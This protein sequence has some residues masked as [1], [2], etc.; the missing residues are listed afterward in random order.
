MLIM[1]HESV[2]QP[3]AGEGRPLRILVAEDNPLNQMVIAAVLEQMGHTSDI[4]ADGEAALRKAQDNV[5]DLILMDMMMPRMDGLSAIRA[6]RALSEPTAHIPIIMMTANAMPQD[7]AKSS[8]AGC[9]GFVPKPID[10]D[11]LSAEVDR[12]TAIGPSRAP[13]RL[14]TFNQPWRPSL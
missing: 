13:S 10:F 6:I 8:A 1:A 7:R 9:N 11:L 2:S 3:H 4:V 12:V 14:G 5:Y